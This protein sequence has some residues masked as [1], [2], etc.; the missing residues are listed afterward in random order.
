MLNSDVLNSLD[1]DDGNAFL[2]PED[3]DGDGLSTCLGD[4]D[5]GDSDLN[6]NDSD[7]DGERF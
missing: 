6:Q 7:G 4:C 2:T 3:A 5:D 1:C